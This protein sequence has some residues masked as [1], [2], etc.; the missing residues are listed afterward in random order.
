MAKT[1]PMPISSGIAAGGGEGDEAGEAADAELRGAFGGH[2]D[3]GG[4]AVGGLRRVAGGDGAVGVED[5][6]EFG[7]G[8][9]RGVGA[10]AFVYLEDGFGGVGLPVSLP[11]WSS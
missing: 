2:D 9:E 1:G 4:G 7:E 6:L 11:W 5:G 3:R 8:F 10:R